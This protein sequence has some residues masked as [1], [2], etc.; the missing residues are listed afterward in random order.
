LTINTYR[1]IRVV[2]WGLGLFCLAVGA[3]DGDDAAGFRS[4]TGP[5]RFSFPEDHGAHPGYRTEWWYYTGN[6]TAVTGERFGFQL[7]FFRRQLRPSD[8]R[9]DWPE[10]ASAWRTN[11]IY[12]AHAALTDLSARRHVMAERVS[13]EALGMA[14]AATELK[15]TRI[16]LNNWETVIAPTKHTLRMTDEAFDLALTLAPTKGPIPHGEEGYSRKGDDPEQAS[17]YYSFPRMAASGR[18]RIAENDYVVSGEAWMDHEFS[19][20]PLAEGVTGWDWFSLQLDNQRELMIYLLR[21]E[22]GGLHP[23]SSGTLIGPGGQAVH[24]SQADFQSRVNRRWTSPTTGATYPL[25]W[26]LTLPGHGL[27]LALTASLDDQEMITTG[28]TGVTYWEGSLS[29]NGLAGGVPVTGQGYM[30]LT[31]YADPYAPPL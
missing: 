1:L 10:P 9:R 21:L 20:A 31:G 28:S 19:T 23:A 27:Q 18:V 5:C 22:T 29:V 25:G 3:V 16:F 14:G 26:E 12:L 7:T 15:E 24:L 17:C 13:R 4:V 2:S 6:L 8:T 11:Q 30:E